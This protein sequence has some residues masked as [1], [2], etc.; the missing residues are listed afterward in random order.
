MKKSSQASRSV[1]IGIVFKFFPAFA[2]QQWRFPLFW[3]SSPSVSSSTKKNNRGM[4]YRW[5]DRF[6]V[7][8]TSFR[9][10]IP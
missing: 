1:S 6:I 3:N 10:G 5:N 4:D 7:Y 2:C 8:L 9:I